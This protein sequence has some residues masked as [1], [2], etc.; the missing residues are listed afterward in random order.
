MSRVQ[1]ESPEELSKE[2]GDPMTEIEESAHKILAL[3]SK[4]R[5]TL[6]K[7]AITLEQAQKELTE[8]RKCLSA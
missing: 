2:K 8:A 5:E 3:L 6:N 7:M 4:Q 1:E